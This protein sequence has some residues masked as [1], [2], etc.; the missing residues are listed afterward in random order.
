MT[1]TERLIAWLDTLPEARALAI[2]EE[3]LARAGYAIVSRKTAEICDRFREE[4]PLVSMSQSE[5]DAVRYEIS[6]TRVAE[7]CPALSKVLV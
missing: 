4:W 7:L 6:T 3:I 5:L 2:V 1:E